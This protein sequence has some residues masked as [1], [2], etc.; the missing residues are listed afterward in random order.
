ME[1]ITF[2]L[3]KRESYNLRPYGNYVIKF[4]T[5][6]GH[7]PHIIPFIELRF[8]YNTEMPID[9]KTDKEIVKYMKK[10]KTDILADNYGRY[11]TRIGNGFA[12]V[13]HHKLQTEYKNPDIRF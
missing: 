7:L 5:R 6:Q 4:K 2:T 3:T 8:D 9:E 10:N 12:Q 13:Y 11:F 1:N